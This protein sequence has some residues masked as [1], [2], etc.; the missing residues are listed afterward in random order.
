VKTPGPLRHLAAKGHVA[1]MTKAASYLLSFDDFATMRR[2]LIDHV[3]WM[4]SDTTGLPP[5]HGTPAGFEY[6]TYGTFERSN[7]KAGGS[8]AP[9]WRAMFRAQPK[10]PLAFRFG[11][12]DG[13]WRGHL[14]VMRRTTR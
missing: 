13:K 6:E 9:A 12:P 1:A 3:D 7:M 8:V 10:R 2:Y 11:Y 4:V 14:V 5:A